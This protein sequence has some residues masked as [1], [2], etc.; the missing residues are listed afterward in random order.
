ML[1]F[2][3]LIGILSMVSFGL[4]DFIEAFATKNAD[5]LV[6]SFWIMAIS[7]IIILPALF[8]FPQNFN[9]SLYDMVLIGIAAIFGSIAISSFLTG[10][11]S[12]FISAVSTVG[13]AWAIVTVTM[14]VFLLNE[15]ITLVQFLGIFL[16]IGGTLAMSV[17]LDGKAMKGMYYGV[18]S[19]FCW[20]VMFFII[21]WLVPKLGVVIPI[22]FSYVFALVIIFMFIVTAR[23]KLNL[24][25]SARLSTFLGAIISMTGYLAY[26]FASQ[27]AAIAIVAP[28]VAASPVVTV[29][30][31]KI[32]IKERVRIIQY[33]G[34]AI[35][36]IGLI[37]LAF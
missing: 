24:Q 22:F 29:M 3:I 27:S 10:L 9:I 13:N 31:S 15:S 16:V 1:I 11:Q 17:R 35:V 33:T 6:V 8:L 25:T 37:V 26:G 5:P 23:I 21:G 12:G 30:L 20:G 32:I 34:I 2:G 19:L 14:G 7:I 4:A 36:I 18:V 28:I